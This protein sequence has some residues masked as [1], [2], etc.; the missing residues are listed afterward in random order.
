LFRVDTDIINSMRHMLRAMED[1]L[2]YGARQILS[3]TYELSSEES[4]SMNQARQELQRYYKQCQLLS[5]RIERLSI[6]LRKVI[7]H[8]EAAEDQLVAMVKTSDLD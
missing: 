6:A 3:A 4:Q 7:S 2:D 5:D 1:E 8:V